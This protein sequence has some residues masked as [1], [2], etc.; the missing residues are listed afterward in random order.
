LSRPLVAV[1]HPVLKRSQQ[2]TTVTRA[3]DSNNV[4]VRSAPLGLTR[5]EE[6]MPGARE[7]RHRVVSAN[8]DDD[9]A[10]DAVRLDD[11]PDNQVHA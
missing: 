6:D 7:Y 1:A 3:A 2:S 9:L 4:A 5:Q 10:A 8:V 11:Q